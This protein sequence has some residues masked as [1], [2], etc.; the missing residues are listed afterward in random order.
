MK[1]FGTDGVRGNTS[2]Q[3]FDDPVLAFVE[4]RIFTK[5]LCAEIVHAANRLSDRGILVI[6]WDRR[7]SNEEIAR[8]VV[9]RLR[10]HVAK[11]VVLSETSTPALQHE[12]VELDAGLGAMITASH[13]PSH[14]SGVK[15]FF[16]NGRKPTLD[17]E[18]SIESN[19]FKENRKGAIQ[20]H[21]DYYNADAYT[22][23][24]VDMARSM[25]DSCSIPDKEILI[26][27]SR[28]WISGWFCE[29]MTSMGINFRE[30]STRNRPI[31]E[32][33]GAGSLSEGIVSWEDCRKSN[34]ALLSQI[35]ECPKGEIIGFSFDG[36]GDRCFLI[37]SDG[38]AARII[39]G[40][41]FLRLS[42]KN[43]QS[44]SI[45]LVAITIQSSLDV[46]E[47]FSKKPGLV[48]IETGVGDR[49]LQHALMN[50]GGSPKLAAEPSGHIIM[51][52]ITAGKKVYWGD[53]LV[54][55]FGYMELINSIGKDWLEIAVSRIGICIN[56][57]ISP[58]NRA[59]WEPD[60]KC[61]QL[62]NAVLHRMFM[63]KKSGIERKK[64]ENE[65]GL[66]LLN[67]EH[68]GSWSIAIRNSG[69]EA[70]TRVTIRSTCEDRNF[71]SLL[72]EKIVATLEP[73][74]LI[75]P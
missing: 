30:V 51:E 18:V 19:L 25:R 70:K 17:E 15:I 22:S 43:V 44:K 61:G 28:G 5:E 8:Y 23:K 40:D 9:D 45:H 24:I 38:N 75:S 27:G 12:M 1:L 67:F 29:K 71:S 69:T 26:D 63:I 35:E 57:S 21:I 68:Q 37:C 52:Q 47:I 64:L 41:G 7:D 59:K 54:S 13:N 72:M 4:S 3:S 6:G 32:N 2:S 55:M 11:I 66:L 53:G 36:D 56:H 42:S 48:L 58:S 20:T 10:T 50:G 46:T 73:E 16:R 39:G 62:V 34:H 33:S 60:G 14:D 49:W 31:N 65:E 74:L